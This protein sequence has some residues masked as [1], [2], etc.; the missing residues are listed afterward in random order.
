MGTGWHEATWLI[1]GFFLGLGVGVALWFPFRHHLK[2]LLAARLE[3]MNILKELQQPEVPQG[4][5][6][7]TD[8]QKLYRQAFQTWT[9]NNT[10]R[11]GLYGPAPQVQPGTS[12]SQHVSSTNP[13][14]T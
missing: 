11:G 14:V 8:P 1:G 7:W 2:R 13:Y 5:H 10:I 9:D 3:T 6:T 12:S 4:S